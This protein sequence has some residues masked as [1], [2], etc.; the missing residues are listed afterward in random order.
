MPLQRMAQPNE[1]GTELD[2][3]AKDRERRRRTKNISQILPT[4][5]QQH[6]K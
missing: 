2:E 6:R 1:N 4:A 5:S 3:K